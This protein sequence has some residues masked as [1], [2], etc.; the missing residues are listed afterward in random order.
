MGQ[1]TGLTS[2]RPLELEEGSQRHVVQ[3][4]VPALLEPLDV[5]LQLFSHEV[6]LANRGLIC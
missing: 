4:L 3:P 1:G 2:G 5:Y 6:G